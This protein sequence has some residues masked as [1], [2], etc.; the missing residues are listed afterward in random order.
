MLAKGD[1]IPEAR[2][3]TAPR[4]APVVLQD[5]LAGTGDVLLCFYTFDWSPG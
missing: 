5:A 3:W 2:V 4:E 1:Q